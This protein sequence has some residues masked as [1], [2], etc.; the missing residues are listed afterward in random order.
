MQE[1]PLSSCVSS[2]W[3]VLARTQFLCPR[4]GQS[5]QVILPMVMTH[6]LEA[7]TFSFETVGGHMG[8]HVCGCPLSVGDRLNIFFLSHILETL[9]GVLLP[10]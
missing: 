8:G 10:V 9:D 2:P 3:L 4:V 1:L 5:S 7:H 6:D